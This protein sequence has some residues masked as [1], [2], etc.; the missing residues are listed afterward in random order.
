M[1]YTFFY[2]LFIVTAYPLQLLYFKRKTYYSGGKKSLRLGK[3]RGGALI[4][5]NHFGVRD[6]FLTLFAALPR[7]LSVVASEYAFRNKYIS[8]GMRF[9]GGIQANRVTKSMRF[10][11]Q[12]AEV[13]RKGGLVQIFPEGQNTDDGTIK[14]FKPSYIAIAHRA[15]APIVPIVTDGN[16]GFFKRTGIII[17]EPIYLSELITPTDKR[18]PPRQELELANTVIRERVLALRRELEELKTAKSKK[19]AEPKGAGNDYV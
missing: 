15:N 5:C 2:W 13:I 18:T 8:F 12:S 16:Y 17:G 3:I 6:F 10:V 14:P 4:I 19:T 11:D 9:C 1:I 7:R